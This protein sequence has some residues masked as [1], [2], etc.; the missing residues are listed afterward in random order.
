MYHSNL[1]SPDMWWTSYQAFRQCTINVESNHYKF[2]G[3]TIWR[4]DVESN[5]HLFVGQTVCRNKYQ[6]ILIRS[7]FRRNDVGNTVY[8]HENRF[9]FI[10]NWMEYDP[11]ELNRTSFGSKSKK[12]CHHDRIPFNS[13][14]VT[15]CTGSPGSARNITPKNALTCLLKSNQTW[16]VI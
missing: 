5:H 16:I 1:C 10:S 7:I 15:P 13:K 2:V 4:N 12:N 11:F 3:Q 14:G 6:I 9:L 8:T